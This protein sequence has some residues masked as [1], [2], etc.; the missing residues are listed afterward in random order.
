MGYTRRALIG[1]PS[2]VYRSTTLYTSDKRS[3][4]SNTTLE[5]QRSSAQHEFRPTM[6][7]ALESVHVQIVAV[8]EMPACRPPLISHLPNTVGAQWDKRQRVGHE[9]EAE[10][11]CKVAIPGK[12]ENRGRY[13][14]VLVEKQRQEDRRCGT[15]CFIARG[16]CCRF[17][18]RQTLRDIP[19]QQCTSPYEKGAG[20]ERMAAL[21]GN[22]FN[23]Q[24][25]KY[26]VLCDLQASTLA[27]Q[28]AI[29]TMR[30]FGASPAFTIFVAA[31][32][33][34]TIRMCFTWCVIS[35]FTV[36]RAATN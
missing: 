11:L 29:D 10:M 25:Y 3:C 14:Y 34:T 22:Y 17:S 23:L 36:W 28:C 7:S 26:A 15:S 12:A 18:L 33:G 30:Q 19:R 20:S 16:D 24:Q 4:S 31:S 2:A 5:Q 21:M 6:N 27:S 1:S 13:Y 35:G 8:K 32:S 9:Q